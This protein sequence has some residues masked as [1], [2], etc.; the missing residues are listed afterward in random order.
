MQKLTDLLRRAIREVPDEKPAEQPPAG[1]QAALTTV[2]AAG[3]SPAPLD[4]P[5]RFLSAEQSHWRWLRTHPRVIGIAVA[6]MVAIVAAEDRLIAAGQWTAFYV[7]M[8]W[9]NAS[10]HP[11][12]LIGSA[13][14]LFYLIFGLRWLYYLDDLGRWLR[15]GF[16]SHPRLA[17]FVG[18]ILLLIG[19]WL[20]NNSNTWV[21]LPFTVGQVQTVSFDGEKVAVQLLAE[22]NQVGVGNPTPALILWDIRE[23]RTS[24]GSVS[25]RRSLPLEECD[26]VLQGPG[27]F[28][29]LRRSI[30]LPRVLTGSQGNRLDLGNLSL[31]TINI[32][33]QIFTQFLLKILPT[34]YREFSGQ[35][36]ENNGELEIS[37][38]SHNP[39]NAWRIAGPGSAYPEMMEYLAL[40]MALDLN[41]DVI[42]SSGLSAPPADPELAFAMGNEAFRQ[43]RY[44]RALA[45][46]E[47]TDRFKPLDEKIDAMLGLAT[48]QLALQQ[49]GDDPKRF[50]A[51]LHLM[52]AAVREDPNGDSSVLRPYLI[53]L[54]HKSGQEEQAAAQNAIF[55]QYLLRLEYQDF[56]VRTAALKQ[57]PLR[58]PGRH[59]AA[60]GGD[61]ILVNEAGDIVGAAG[62]PLSQGLVLPN[63]KA[64]PGPRQI[65]I[66]GQGNLLYISPDGAVLAYPY[67]ETAITPTLKTL[68]EGRTLQGIEQIGTSTSL[69]GRDNL[70]LLNRLGKTYWCEPGA[71][72]GSASACPPRQPLLAEQTTPAD[73][74]QIFPVEDR[75]YMLAAD[76]A[77]WYTEININGQAI[78]PRQLTQP[79][80]VQE[81]FAAGDRT[82]Y[83]LHEN[84]NVWRYYDD[85][86]A[87]TEDN[88]L[89]DPGTGTVQIFAAGGYLYVLKNNGEVW[90]ISNPRNPAPAP[91]ADF[92]KIAAQPQ[93]TTIQEIFVTTDSPPGQETSNSRAIYLLTD[94]RKLL[95][96]TD[97]GGSQLTL[98]P[99]NNPATQ[100][101]AQ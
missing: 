36:S 85:G 95:V 4:I 58:G 101:P 84:G 9:S 20:V 2:Q 3:P 52:E 67:R 55:T 96:G 42:Q 73:V 99:V 61:V 65:G 19:L 13:L 30:P 86:L 50:G 91:S 53:C 56:D 22:L 59:L 33:S 24:S 63:E 62:Q 1:D 88:K 35:I 23:P 12:A 87:A 44:G 40:R 93:D 66:Y 57:T 68:I 32:P 14:I 54:Y 60:L 100:A 27:G 75:L 49:P 16:K 38:S 45:F 78:T 94:R 34:G 28:F 82:L 77:V 97:T 18:G 41:P 74:R 6:L 47:L 70:F 25:S 64:S 48:Y 8:F 37:V 51:A 26:T 81:I 83:L 31:G 17:T 69:F 98:A 71:E 46:Y 76:G 29:S 11:V 39:P 80:P 43:Q 90:R 10:G 5:Q 21:V 7:K 89:I 15:G 72:A 79:A 92:A